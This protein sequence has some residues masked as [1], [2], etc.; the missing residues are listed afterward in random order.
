[1]STSE[2]ELYGHLGIVDKT[3]TDRH[4]FCQ[5]FNLTE[6]SFSH[7]EIYLLASS[8]KTSSCSSMSFSTIRI[9]AL[10][11]FGTGFLTIFLE[12]RCFMKKFYHKISSEDFLEV[13]VGLVK[14]FWSFWLP[15]AF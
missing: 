4:T 15:P 6:C 7:F 1:M 12:I 13:F 11:T 14:T 10:L 9:Y 3:G 5:R 2:V 8:L